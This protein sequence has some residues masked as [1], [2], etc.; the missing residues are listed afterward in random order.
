MTGRPRLIG[1]ALGHRIEELARELIVGSEID[2]SLELFP[3]V[4]EPRRG[5]P[6]RR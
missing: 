5:L 4:L 2:D 3:R 6:R 1:P